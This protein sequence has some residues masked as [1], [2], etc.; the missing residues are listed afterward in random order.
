MGVAI[1]NLAKVT[2]RFIDTHSGD[3]G[4]VGGHG[5]L[6]N[7]TDTP[8]YNNYNLM[9]PGYDQGDLLTGAGLLVYACMDKRQSAD[10]YRYLAINGNGRLMTTSAGGAEQRNGVQGKLNLLLPERSRRFDNDVAFWANV[11]LASVKNPELALLVHLKKCGGAAAQETE[12]VVN[13]WI[14]NGVERVKM[15]ER[16][17]SMRNAIWKA[18]KKKGKITIGCV[19]IDQNN[20]FSGLT[21]V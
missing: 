16:A 11:L 18:T 21:F 6:I 2:S 10:V 5:N 14:E 20:Q 19:T 3:L 9:L 1:E 17:E 15:I 7:I 12:Q 4:Y 13:T 8:E